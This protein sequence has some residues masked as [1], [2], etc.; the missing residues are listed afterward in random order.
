[1]GFG[2]PFR[3][4]KINFELGDVRIKA[5]DANHGVFIRS[6]PRHMHSFYE[7]HYIV[8]GEGRL[9][10][11]DSE[12]E[13][14]KGK[15]FL[16][17]PKVHHAQL[18]DTS[19]C[20]EEYYFSFEVQ[21]KNSKT[22]CTIS[23]FFSNSDFYM[24]DDTR[25]VETVFLE[26]E[27]ELN[28]C[29]VGYTAAV[30][31]LLERILLLTVRNFLYKASEMTAARTVPDDRRSLLMDEA[32]LFS[33][34][35]LTLESLSKLLNLSARHTERLIYEKYGTSFVNMRTQSR[36]NAAMDM[37]A[38]NRLKLCE[39]AESCG[40]SSYIHFLNT[41]KNAFG[42]APSEY[43]KTYAINGGKQK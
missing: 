19:N 40:F 10:L 2:V 28:N 24:C 15:L 41:F 5:I 30:R 12:Y 18:T 39:I 38:D 3:D 26:V 16:L 31:S 14:S 37:L 21:P 25:A 35:T 4:F 32:F 29:E 7:L 34:K 42:A 11:D 17:A 23:S 13:L 43:R 33:Y 27:R 6:F 22:D 9:I 1:M 8:G 20:M 36:L